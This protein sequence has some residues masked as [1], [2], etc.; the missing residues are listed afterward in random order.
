M[1]ARGL[2]KVTAVMTGAHVIDSELYLDSILAAV[3]PAMHNHSRLTRMSETGSIQAPLPICSVFVD[4]KRVVWCCSSADYPDGYAIDRT[5]FV[6]R[7]DPLDVHYAARQF[8][9]ASE[10]FASVSS[11]VR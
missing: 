2:Y 11:A 10:Q 1:K 7:R 9:P 6:K 5:A 4:G 3:H 8:L